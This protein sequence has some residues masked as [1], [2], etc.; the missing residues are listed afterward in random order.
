MDKVGLLFLTAAGFL[1]GVLATLL[2]FLAE[3]KITW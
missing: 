2:W 3:G 1:A